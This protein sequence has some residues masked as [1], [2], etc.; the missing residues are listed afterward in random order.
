MYQV[1][2]FIFHAFLH[3]VPFL[4]VFFPRVTATIISSSDVAKSFQRKTTPMIHTHE[5]E[6][7]RLHHLTPVKSMPDQSYFV[8]VREQELYSY[9]T[10]VMNKAPAYCFHTF[11]LINLAQ[12]NLFSQIL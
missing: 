5:P 7:H 2:G 11:L 4:T 10:K 8:N 12:K 9:N 3:Y 6:V 1:G